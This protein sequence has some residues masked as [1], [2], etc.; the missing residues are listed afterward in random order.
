M[1]RNLL[2]LCSGTISGLLPLSVNVDELHS[3]ATYL[4]NDPGCA[5]GP[6]GGGGAETSLRTDRTACNSRYIQILSRIYRINES[7]ATPFVTYGWSH[8]LRE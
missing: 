2:H 1:F 8:S 5:G 3:P 4:S 7:S 6:S